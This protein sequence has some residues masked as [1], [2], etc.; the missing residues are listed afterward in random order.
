[1]INL[2]NQLRE[3]DFPS[4]VSPKVD[5]FRQKNIIIFL[6]AMIS[7]ILILIAFFSSNAYLKF[8][9][10]AGILVLCL[11]F[12][13]LR[14]LVLKQ[15]LKKLQ[16]EGDDLFF[17]LE[18][19]EEVSLPLMLGQGKEKLA[20]FLKDLLRKLLQTQNF[21]LFLKI[22]KS[23]RLF[24]LTKKAGFKK[25]EFKIDDPLIAL[26]QKQSGTS[27]FNLSEKKLPLAGSITGLKGSEFEKSIHLKA[28]NELVGLILF[29]SDKSDLSLEE[30]KLLNL[31]SRKLLWYLETEDLRRKLQK[32]KREYL[33]KLSQ[34][35]TSDSLSQIELKRKIFDFHSLYQA[36]NQLYL[37]LDQNRLFYNFIQILQRQLDPKSVIIFLPEGKD[38]S[39]RA[40]YS[41]GV[42]LPAFS[43]ISLT[44]QDPLFEKLKRGQKVLYLYQLIEEHKEDKLLTKCTGY[45]FQLCYPLRLPDNR[46][47]LVF[48]GG[49]TEGLRY[50]EEDFSILSF[51]GEVL[52]VSLRNISQYRK[53][54]ELSYTDSLSGLYNYRYFRKRLSEEIFRAKRYQRKLTLVILDID[55]FKSYNDS[56]GHQS[57]DQII[58]QLGEEIIKVV[59]SI[60]V[61]CRYGGDEFCII[62]PE[63]D[64]EECLKFLERL[65]KHIHQ[66]TFAD[67][68]LQLEHHLSLSAGGAIYPQHARTS[69][70]L[71][72][73]ADMALLRAKSSGRNKSFVYSGEEIDLKNRVP[74]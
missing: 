69:E 11:Y 53:L 25:R 59:R 31:L 1:V 16:K 49:R 71:I 20:S 29:S 47:G 18:R 14:A 64:Q 73:C 61:V 44:Q 33:H 13:S 36:A 46:I 37:S 34:Q 65:R 22:E 45:G 39:L 38:M 40:K 3:I 7:L 35:K 52:N 10:L 66:H 12:F 41:K 55:E 70:R 4:K 2:D 24:S 57:G 62:M 21:L 6:W 19:L 72:Y 28:G 26:L 54:E 56:F 68:F 5:I 27:I 51:L 60:D 74:L 43:E 50:R 58:K 15:R 17:M 32:E 48:L 9:G 67:D 42:D 30:G 8:F 23:Y 63:T